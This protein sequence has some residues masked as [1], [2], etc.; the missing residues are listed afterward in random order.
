M[1]LCSLLRCCKGLCSGVTYLCPADPHPQLF[2][3]DVEVEPI[4]EVLVGKTMEQALL[5]V[6]EEEELA[7]LWAHQRAYAELRNAELAEVQRLEEQDRRYREEKVRLTRSKTGLPGC[8]SGKTKTLPVL[9]D[10][11]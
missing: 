3:F 5:E 11:L 1:L 2:D 9:K 7:Q 4:L 10:K 8:P 6:M